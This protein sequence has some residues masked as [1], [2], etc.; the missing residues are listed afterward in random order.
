MLALALALRGRLESL[1]VK[2]ALGPLA[3]AIATQGVE[4]WPVVATKGQ[5][6]LAGR[7]RQCVGLGD[8]MCARAAGK[9]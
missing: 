6:E 2:L 1:P 3:L 5:S 7:L 4:L 9:Q 8:G